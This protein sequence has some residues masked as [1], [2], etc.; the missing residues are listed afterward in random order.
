MSEDRDNRDTREPREPREPRDSRNPNFNQ[1]NRGNRNNRD[2]GGNRGGHRGGHSMRP[3]GR[4][5]RP[6]LTSSINGAGLCLV[7]LAVLF[8]SSALSTVTVYLGL[9]T[10]VFV[11]SSLISYFAQRISSMRWLE[12][13]SDFF[14]F[15]GCI[16]VLIVGL[17]LGDVL[18]YLGL[19]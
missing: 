16:L 15:A 10:S 18:S 8:K 13:V 9:A 1:F 2:R 6:L 19:S 12:K 17:Q 7:A 11:M 5:Q 4:I 14:F 3:G